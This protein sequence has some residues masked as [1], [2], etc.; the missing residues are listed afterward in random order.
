MEEPIPLKDID[1]AVLSGAAVLASMLLVF[2]GFL[3]AH[4]ESFPSDVPDRI[5]ARYK[6]AARWGLVPLTLSMAVMLVSYL[7]LF[8]PGSHLL[9]IGWSWGFGVAMGIFLLYALLSILIV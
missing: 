5:T 4:A 7:W 2:I 1:L 9:F 8:N 6:N 3:L